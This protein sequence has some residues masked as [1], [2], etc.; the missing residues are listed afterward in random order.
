[1]PIQALLRRKINESWTDR[2]CSV[3]RHKCRKHCT[4]LVGRTKRS[5]EAG[6]RNRNGEAQDGPLS[7]V[8]RCQEPDPG[9]QIVDVLVLQVDVLEALQFQDSGKV[10]RRGLR[11]GKVVDQDP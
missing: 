5:V 2:H 4:T 3:M 11:Q 6:K 8:E 9:E 10:L 1:M 7:V